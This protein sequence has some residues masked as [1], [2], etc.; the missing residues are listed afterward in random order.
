MTTTATV[1]TLTH[2]MGGAIATIRSPAT[3][4]RDDWQ[5]SV[6]ELELI[7]NGRHMQLANGDEHF[8]ADPAQAV[9]SWA[10]LLVSIELAGETFRSLDDLRGVAFGVRRAFWD[11]PDPARQGRAGNAH[12]AFANRVQAGWLLAQFIAYPPSAA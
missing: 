1:R 12:A 2:E 8:Y 5:A 6:A 9:T 7:A 3:L 10:R 4:R 11:E